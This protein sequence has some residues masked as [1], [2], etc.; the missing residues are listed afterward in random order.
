MR[1]LYFVL[2]FLL[3][4]TLWIYYPRFKNVNIPKKRFA[5][6]IYMSNH[7]SSFM[8][9]LVVA[10]T[11]RPIIFF[12]TRSDIFTPMLKPILWASHMFP[13][14]RKHD[15]EDTKK[16][17]EE[18]FKKC[19]RVLKY[20]R[21]LLVFS[22]GFTDDVFVR[23]LKPVKKGA[24]RIGF[25]ALESNNW[26]KK[27]FV[28]GVGVNYSDPKVL[29]SDCLVSNA[30]PVCLNDYKLEYD[31]D[32]NKTIHELTLKLEQD[33]R[34]QI[35]DIRNIDMT[36]FHEN[37]MRLTR[38]GMS[39][40][41]SDKSISLLNRWKYSKQL[42]D[43]FN[44]TKVEECEGLMKLKTRLEQYFITL[45]ENRIEE[46]PL[47]KV[48]S[49]KRKK[50]TDIFYL[51]ALAPIMILGL[52]LNYLPYILIKRFVEKTFKRDVFWSSVKMLLGLVA[53][54][55]YNFILFFVVAKLFSLSF[56]LLLFV[57]LFL[58]TFSAV[59]TLNWFKTL[60]LHKKMNKVEVMDPSIFSAICLERE[61][62]LS[63]IHEQIPV[64]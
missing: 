8:D 12:M 45:K 9:P 39:E 11:Q 19:G 48:I 62:L 57:G 22:E 31:K 43:W 38:K 21:S 60:K 26:R 54:G 1:P 23:R 36:E 46:T 51:F 18:V 40:S 50:A 56:L 52:I 6:T 25:L 4:I 29:G 3:K 14:Y 32:P 37:I 44:V 53:V 64:A 49:N 27:V 35:T 20:G 42:A 30:T 5:R 13:I 28:Q 63:E 41:D 16:K 47:Y 59:I 10:G 33:I 61:S 7:A 15:G 58:V 17:N 34:D 2:K 24:I 55:L